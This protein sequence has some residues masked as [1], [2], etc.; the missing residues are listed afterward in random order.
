MDNN[1]PIKSVDE[2]IAAQPKDVAEKLSQ[3]RAIVKNEAPQ[4]TEKIS[5]GMPYYSLNGR[6]LYFR[7]H[8]HHIGL[9]PMAAT[10]KHF[11]KELADYHTSKGTVQLPLNK[12]LPLGLIRK[13]VH[14]R[15]EEKMAGVK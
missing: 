2:Y 13:I 12:P 7:A 4:A 1:N 8:A 10:V 14:F 9:Y 15:A 11:E 6:L 3:I 5:Y